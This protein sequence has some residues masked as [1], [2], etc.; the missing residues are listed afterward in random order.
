MVSFSPPA[1]F[2]P[3][4]PPP[5]HPQITRARI[6]L[7]SVYPDPVFQNPDGWK[8]GVK[9]N[10]TAVIVSNPKDG[11]DVK[12]YNQVRGDAKLAPTIATIGTNVLTA[13]PTTSYSQAEAYAR[14]G[15]QY[16]VVL[17]KVDQHMVNQG[18]WETAGRAAEGPKQPG[19]NPCLLVTGPV[20]LPICLGMRLTV[21]SG[22]NPVFPS[23]H[24]CHKLTPP[25]PAC[26]PPP[27]THTNR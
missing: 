8:V 19:G 26:P 4:L 22:W 5:T 13:N 21:G 12:V 24:L 9:V 25:A 15:L 14:P 17:S 6:G 16:G 11:A 20:S 2:P 27:L 7:T 1:A 18:E 10:S 3:P 23:P